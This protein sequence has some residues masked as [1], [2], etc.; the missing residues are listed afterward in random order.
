MIVAL[1][2]FKLW[3]ETRKKKLPKQIYL[4]VQDKVQMPKVLATLKE[5]YHGV[6][7]LMD[8]QYIIFVIKFFSN[9]TSFKLQ[10]L[11]HETN[12]NCSSSNPA[13]V[14]AVDMMFLKH[15][16]GYVG[17][18][19]C[20]MDRLVSGLRLSYLPMSGE[21]TTVSLSDAWYGDKVF[22]KKAIQ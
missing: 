3:E 15:T 4:G 14:D 11:T 8:M 9:C 20:P 2:M 7:E 16:D 1:E 22:A 13:L 6:K 5:G 21:R 17:S 18:G 10:I 19:N 12:V